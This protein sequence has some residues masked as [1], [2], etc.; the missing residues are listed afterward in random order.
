LLPR[1]FAIFA[2]SESKP[3][4]VSLGLPDPAEV[5]LD[6]EDALGIGKLENG[7]AMLLVP[8]PGV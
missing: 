6:V 3:S 5:V 8:K 1:R 2:A 7:S 4:P